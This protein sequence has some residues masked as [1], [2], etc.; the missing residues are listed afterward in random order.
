MLI[1][2]EIV[3]LKEIVAARFVS[4]NPIDKINYQHTLANGGAR[5]Q[6]SAWRV[7][8]APTLSTKGPLRY[9][10]LANLYD[11]VKQI[12]QGMDPNNILNRARCID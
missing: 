6:Q 2:D 5:V 12:K 10:R 8:T 11:L 4:T 1:V 3:R 7:W 9:E